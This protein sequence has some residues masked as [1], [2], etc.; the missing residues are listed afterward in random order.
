MAN[1]KEFSWWETKHGF[2]FSEE[3]LLALLEFNDKVK[4]NK[5]W[6]AAQTNVKLRIQLEQMV[7]EFI[8]QIDPIS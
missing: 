3:D 1:S 5:L 4:D 7:K 2:R 6:P 8:K